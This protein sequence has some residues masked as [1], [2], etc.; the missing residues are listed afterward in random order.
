MKV[1]QCSGL[2]LQKDI[3]SVPSPCSRLGSALVP[4]ASWSESTTGC[5]TRRN[6][7]FPLHHQKA[8]DL[9]GLYR[10]TSGILLLTYHHTLRA[11]LS[12]PRQICG[13]SV[14]CVCVCV[15]YHYLVPKW[16]RYAPCLFTRVSQGL[17]G[18]A[19][20]MRQ[21]AREYWIQVNT[22]EYWIQE[23]IECR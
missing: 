16:V 23:N 8:L 20:H 5:R 18:G 4:I 14:Q 15:Y 3:V 11:F 10:Q 1:R 21:E 19:Q 9:S 7:T 2:L 17:G 6:M 12:L 13:V 22:R